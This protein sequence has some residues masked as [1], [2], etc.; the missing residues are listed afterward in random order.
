MNIVCFYYKR[1]DCACSIHLLQYRPRFSTEYVWLAWD[2]ARLASKLSG[3]RAGET[4]FAQHTVQ[5]G[6]IGMAAR[7]GQKT[8]ST[9]MYTNH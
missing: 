3:Q 6:N 4:L 7:L 9:Q 1:R 8:E 2:L 5:E